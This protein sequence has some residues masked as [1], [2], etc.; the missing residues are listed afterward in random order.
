MNLQLMPL[1]NPYTRLVLPQL[2]LEFRMDRVIPGANEPT[3]A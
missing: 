2:N 1:Q 3:H